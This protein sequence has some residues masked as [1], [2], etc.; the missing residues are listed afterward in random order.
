MTGVIQVLYLYT[1]LEYTDPSYLPF[2]YIR[3]DSG[4][5]SVPLSSY[6]DPIVFW[7]SVTYD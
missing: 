2:T 3:T 4:T 5:N 7:V 6:S 1:K